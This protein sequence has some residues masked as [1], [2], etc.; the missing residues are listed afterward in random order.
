MKW[1]RIAEAWMYRDPQ[2]IVDGLIA[3]HARRDRTP[4]MSEPSPVQRD[5]YYTQARRLHVRQVM[6]GRR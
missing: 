4:A 5:R 6:K 1:P 3:L 2:D